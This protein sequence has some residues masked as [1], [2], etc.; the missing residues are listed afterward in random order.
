[1]LY[2]VL[3]VVAS[4]YYYYLM[5][6]S[7]QIPIHNHFIRK[8]II[9]Q[10]HYYHLSGSSLYKLFIKLIQIL[11]IHQFLFVCVNIKNHIDWRYP[12]S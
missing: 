1:M 9:M 11:I 4:Q 7:Q 3:A 6:C 5:D 10:G 2:S 8:M 12:L